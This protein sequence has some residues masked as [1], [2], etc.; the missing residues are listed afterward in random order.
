VIASACFNRAT[1]EFDLIGG[2]LALLTL[3]F[4]PNKPPSLDGDNI[5]DTLHGVLRQRAKHLAG[6]I[7]NR[8][9]VASKE[10][11]FAQG[12]VVANG[13]LNISSGHKEKRN[14]AHEFAKLGT[15]DNS[16]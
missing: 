6:R 14:A 7:E 5:G 9:I 11:N 16:D 3:S 15:H 8:L 12:K 1:A 13:P 2:W 10:K 4:K